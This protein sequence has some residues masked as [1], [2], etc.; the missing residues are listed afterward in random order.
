MILSTQRHAVHYSRGLNVH[1]VC[2]CVCV[3]LCA[4]VLQQMPVQWRNLTSPGKRSGWEMLLKKRERERGEA[5][6]GG[7]V[8]GERESKS[9]VL[10]AKQRGIRMVLCRAGRQRAITLVRWTTLSCKFPNFISGEGGFI[11]FF[12]FSSS[13]SDRTCWFFWVDFFHS[14]KQI[15]QMYCDYVNQ[16][17]HS[18]QNVIL[19]YLN[20]FFEV[21]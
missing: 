19:Q 11:I 17:K 14:T 18:V 8:P 10:N 5:K 15:L 21:Y 12:F 16:G 7:M 6:E 9:S 20:W 3:C 13:T 4:R 1:T 2:M